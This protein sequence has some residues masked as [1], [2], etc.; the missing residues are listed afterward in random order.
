VTA[1]LARAL[2]ATT[3]TAFLATLAIVLISDALFARLDAGELHLNT[4]LLGWRPLGRLATADA[5]LSAVGRSLALLLVT[6]AGATLLGVAA[7]LLHANASWRPV[8]A[9]LWL[10][11]T[12]GASLPTFFW[13]VAAQLALISLYEGSSKAVWLLPHFGFGLDEHL[14]LP[15]FALGLRP[16]SYVFRLTA[17]AIDEVR[18]G[19]YVRTATA[20]GLSHAAV[21]RRHVVPNA[22]P[23][24]AAGTVLGARAALSS[25][26]IVEFFFGWGGAGVSFIQAVVDRNTGVAVALLMMFVVLSS[27]LGAASEA[28]A[29][30]RAEAA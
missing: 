13:A 20:K 6:L 12:A 4:S 29:A 27:A 8:R 21:M 24:M 26:A 5:L 16:A 15:A 14:V 23:G 28:L 11:G 2:L 7:A 18:R 1:A 25:L 19:E 17:S 30:R 3:V 22:L 9:G 10:L